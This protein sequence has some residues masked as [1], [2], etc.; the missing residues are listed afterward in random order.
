MSVADTQNRATRIA[1][2][3]LAPAWL[4]A[5][6]DVNRLVPA[7]WAD[8]VERGPRG[9][10]TI[11]G[12]P[13]GELKARFGTPLFVMSEGDFRHRARMFKDAF[14]DAFADICGGVDVYYAGK[15]FLC[16]EVAR[17][18]DS[19]GLRLDTCSGGELAVATRA[20]LTGGKL[21]LH[22]NNK[23]DA[24][25]NRALD[26]GLGRIVVDSLHELRRVADL[27]AAKAVTA[28]V[29]LRVTPGV[30]AHTHESIATAHED[31]KFGLSLVSPETGSTGELSAAEAAAKL[32]VESGS[33]NFLGFHAHIGSQI[34][35]AE[36][37]E[38]AARKLLTF[39]HEIQA[40]YGVTLR[41]LDLGGGYGI[42]YTAVDTPRPAAEIAQAMAAVVRQTCAELGMAA[43]RISIEP[44]RAIVGPST[45]TLYETGTLKTVQ[46]EV[47]GQAGVTA[48]RRYVSVDGGMSD[49]PRPVL[50]DA[51]YSAVVAGRASQAAPALSR[52]VGKHC[53]SGDIVVRDVYLPNDVAAGDLLA[54]PGTGAYCWA[55]ASNYNYVPRPPVVAVKDGAARLI[56][57]G[58]TEDDLLARDLGA[59]KPLTERNTTGTTVP[60]ETRTLKVALLGAG[61]VGSQVARILLEDADSLA[62]RTGARLELAGIAVRNI[63]APRD[64]ELPREL[65][66]TDASALVRGADVVIELMGGLEPARA[67]ILEAIEHGATV[68]TGNKALLAVDGPSLYEKAD[69]AG[70]QLSYE[71]AVAG[72]I[73]ILRPI[74]DSLAGDK[75]TRVM[76]IV[77]GTTNFILDQM[78]TTGA[79]FADAL[80]Q[81]TRLGYAEA[82]P[83]ADIEGH[84]A[85]AKGAILASLSFHTRFA[86]ED[87]H[88]QGITSVTAAD[89]AAA[90]DA[91]FVIKLLAI[92]EKLPVPA[93]S[94][95]DDGGHSSGVSV[96]VHPT[97]LPREHPLAA[98]HGA[99]NAVFIE[100]ESAGQLMFYGQGA[101]GTPT[102]SAVLGDVVSAARRLVLGGPGRTE[103]TTGVLPVLGIEA[104]TTQYYIGLDAADQPGVL[105][106]ISALFAEHGVSIETM[107]QTV[108]R[109]RD[110]D[111]DGGAGSAELRIV[112]HRASEAA[113]AATVQAIKG[114]D[115][116]NSVTSVLRV[117]GV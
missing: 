1:G 27:A 26:L 112:T 31:Q 7:M 51:D 61:N 97:L 72:A 37:F 58:E 107:R 39:T 74:R 40:R 34:F 33:I 115:I 19:E 105:A 66:T 75:I 6:G 87:V 57:R 11:S 50:Y 73:P 17:W 65:F 93:P 15:S 81:A 103:T 70:V 28:N 110:A 71:A 16:T 13:V 100:A 86:L 44:G 24:E 8:D 52:V 30:H 2:A 12:V 49:N 88:C 62:A 114:L 3:E 82:D 83:T 63:D 55:L 43:P 96:R 94:G 78:D 116:I 95:K 48:P 53:E 14:D 42:A 38:I 113:L 4:P 109:E 18:V 32:A 77:N 23:S 89:V 80:A 104:V 21:G 84:D 35:E 101:G 45:F 54:V 36:G 29:M 56:V 5:A 69:A 9:E 22:G 47:D 41:E 20:G 99:F 64:V 90:K 25:I 111:G 59:W 85:A 92:A 67:L 60:A 98:V 102:A 91:G 76:G 46:V 79:P 10:L 68:V 108:H 117:E 106:K